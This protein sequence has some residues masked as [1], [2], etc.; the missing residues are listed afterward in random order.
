MKAC[1]LTVIEQTFHFKSH[2]LRSG[3][4]WYFFKSSFIQLPA[5]NDIL[6]LLPRLCS[7]WV[8]EGTGA[9]LPPRATV[10]LLS[11]YSLSA[12]LAQ[13]LPTP[14]AHSSSKFTSCWQASNRYN[15]NSAMIC[16]TSVLSLHKTHTW[17]SLHRNSISGDSYFAL[18]KLSP[19]HFNV[20]FGRTWW[21]SWIICQLLKWRWRGC[22]VLSNGNIQPHLQLIL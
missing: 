5:I 6:P 9:P 21:I 20:R 17:L 7:R 14:A 12:G 15:R 4:I 22:W 3:L 19:F 1:P 10:W 13:L 2:W 11:P 18:K 8:K 16:T